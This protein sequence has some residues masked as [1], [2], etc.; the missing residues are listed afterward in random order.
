MPAAQPGA[1]G[2]DRRTDT[3]AEEHG[4]S[5]GADVDQC[6]GG[7]A[8]RGAH[9]QHLVPAEPE[10]LPGLFGEQVLIDSLKRRLVPVKAAVVEDL[11]HVSPGS[12]LHFAEPAFQRLPAGRNAG[13]IP[14][15]PER[16]G[17]AVT[18]HVLQQFRDSFSCLPHLQRSSGH[19]AVRGFAQ[20]LAPFLAQFGKSREQLH[21]LFER[22]RNRVELPDD[23]EI[24]RQRPAP[25]SHMVPGSYAVDQCHAGPPGPAQD[26]HLGVVVRT[27]WHRPIDDVQYSRAIDDGFQKFTLRAE[28]GVLPVFFQES[29]DGF[30]AVRR[31]T[32][33]ALHPVHCRPRALESRC[34]HQAAQLPAVESDGVR[35]I[36]CRG[37]GAGRDAH[38]RIL[39]QRGDDTALALVRMADNGEYRRSRVGGRV[40]HGGWTST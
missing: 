17:F 27:V 31:G 30:G 3:A 22:F 40:G 20:R 7:R 32:R 15:I 11:L 16:G 39:C 35:A 6:A 10:Q 34:I 13:L 18:Q 12:A 1:R 33:M 29:P 26:F 25:I 5:A 19:K 2:A 37:A 21:L 23:P 38:R 14:G 8:A 28:P 4:Q 36:A 24:L 9:G